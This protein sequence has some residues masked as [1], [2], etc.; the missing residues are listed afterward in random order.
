MRANRWIVPLAALAALLPTG[1][2]AYVGPG[3]GLGALVAL[4]AVVGA[5]L[6]AL[7]G[8]IVFPITMLRRRRRLQSQ[9]AAAVAAASDAEEDD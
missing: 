4:A 6:V 9:E 8:V 7:F 5:I 3:A 2:M 1:A